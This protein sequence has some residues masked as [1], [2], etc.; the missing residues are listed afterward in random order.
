VTATLALLPPRDW[1][2]HG[3]A[4]VFFSKYQHSGC[5]SAGQRFALVMWHAA[6][7]TH[8]AFERRRRKRS[9]RQPQVGARVSASALPGSRSNKSCFPI[10]SLT[11]DRQLWTDWHRIAVRI[12]LRCLSRALSQARHARTHGGAKKISADAQLLAYCAK[13]EN[14]EAGAVVSS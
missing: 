14:I 10:I 11:D 13:L 9:C 12:F 2:N 7:A 5:K 1:P 8:L 3:A 6:R 4:A